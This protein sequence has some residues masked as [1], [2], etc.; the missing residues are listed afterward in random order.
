MTLLNNKPVQAILAI[1][2]SV[3]SIL[4]FIG[5]L[6]FFISTFNNVNASKGNGFAEMGDPV[7]INLIVAAAFV[8]AGLFMIST[9]Y[10]VLHA[11]QNPLLAE[12][13]MR[14]VWILIVILLSGLGSFIYWL[15]E[16]CNKSPRPLIGSYQSR[17]KQTGWSG[18]LY[19]KG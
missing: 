12:G 3:L 16:I 4:C 1:G 13:S 6:F 19:M 11:A 5:Y 18:G 10:F 14:I 17:E 7:N 2:P 9:V 15:V 8:T